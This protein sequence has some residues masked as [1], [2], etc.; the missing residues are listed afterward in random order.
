MFK[1]APAPAPE[2][3]LGSN[4]P[5]SSSGSG[6]PALVR[7]ECGGLWML[8]VTNVVCY[9]WGLLWTCSVMN[10]LC[11]ERA[12][13]WRCSVMNGSV[14]IVVCY[15]CCLLRIWSFMNVVC[16]ECGLLWML[17]DMN[18]VCYAGVLWSLSVMNVVCY[19]R[20]LQW[21][22]S[23]VNMV[24]HERCLQWKGLVWMWSVINMDCCERV[25]VCE[26]GLLWTWCNMN[27]VSYEHVL[28]T[29][30]ITD[31]V[32]SRLRSFSNCNI[33]PTH[34]PQHQILSPNHQ[35]SQR[36]WYVE[37]CS[38]HTH[39]AWIQK[40]RK[41]EISLDT[42]D[43]APTLL[44][45]VL[46]CPFLLNQRCAECVCLYFGLR[47]CGQKYIIITCDRLRKSST[48]V[49]KHDDVIEW[50]FVKIVPPEMKSWLCPRINH[51]TMFKLLLK[52]NVIREQRWMLLELQNSPSRGFAF[53]GKMCTTI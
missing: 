27:V 7:W 37:C 17:S 32:H 53:D 22:W 46:F 49:N 26:R 1:K 3:M 16:Y 6:S 21:T 18:M 48:T 20:G 31:H 15:E 52:L 24:C 34:L 4:A 5:G 38:A 8:S 12:L 29:T 9:E 28:L 23:V 42:G 44:Q 36:I 33:N 43:S 50:N 39:L 11:N 10:V 47:I 30:F 19:E 45:K 51:S 13:Q 41:W 14:M 35:F 25:C 2:K 40:F